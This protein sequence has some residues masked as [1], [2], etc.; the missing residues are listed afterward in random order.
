MRLTPKYINIFLNILF[1]V[2]WAVAIFL[3]FYGF[4]SSSGNLFIKLLNAFLHFF[5]GIF[6]IL[7]LEAIAKI[8]EIWELQQKILKEIKTLKEDNDKVCNN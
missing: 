5:F 1:G 4:S 2:A 6:L 3:L 8:F 7:F